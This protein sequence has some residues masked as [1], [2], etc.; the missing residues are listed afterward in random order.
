VRTREA[1]RE[2]RSTHPGLLDAVPGEA[3]PPSDARQKP[4]GFSL[5][6][7]DPAKKVRAL[8]SVYVNNTQVYGHRDPGVV[9]E[10]LLEAVD[11]FMHSHEVGTYMLT[12]C[13]IDGRMGLY[14]SDF[15]NRSPYR[16]ELRR[17]GARFSDHPFVFFRE[18]G[19]F[20]SRDFGIFRPEFVALGGRSDKPPGVI[21][22]SGA[23]LVHAVAFYRIADID[24]R[25]L[26][27]LT[28]QLTRMDGLGATAAKDL[29]AAIAGRAR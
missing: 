3:E 29:Y 19:L 23:R 2:V 12:A 10:R 16:V 20:E 5:V 9:V 26:A 14:G 27:S 15:Y 11:A 7:D 4:G 28:A 18:T 25:E 21:E 6:L 17:L 24:A 1:W 13:E 22:T 8:P